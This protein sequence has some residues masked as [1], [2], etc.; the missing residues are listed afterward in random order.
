MFSKKD[1]KDG[2]IA[3]ARNQSFWL[4]CNEAFINSEGFNFID[5][6][7]EDLLCDENSDYD[8]IKVWGNDITK[9]YPNYMTLQSLNKIEKLG[10]IY[11][12]KETD[13]SKVKVDTKILVSC[14]GKRWH[15]RHFA[16]YENGK[17]YTFI[18]GLTSFT[19]E[20][21]SLNNWKYAKLYEE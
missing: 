16:K 13:W 18:G 14:E 3:Q 5:S 8:I 7:S 6:Y 21:S 4:V 19:D 2:M 9:E 11:E 10:T 20:G 17:I 1:L 12:R 15:K